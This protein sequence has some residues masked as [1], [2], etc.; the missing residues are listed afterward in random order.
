MYF[1]VSAVCESNVEVWQENES[2]RSAFDAFCL[3]IPVIEKLRD[4]QEIENTGLKACSDNITRLRFSR[5]RIKATSD[6][7]R[8]LFRETDE[9]MY[10]RLD[11]E[12]LDFKDD[13]P[14]FYYQY[15]AAR[16]MLYPATFK[17]KKSDMPLVEN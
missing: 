3:K 6:S 11:R 17:E 4:S 13:S 2:F 8:K 14:D 15:H 5:N 16:I 7:L 9:L 1:T 10:N 12:I